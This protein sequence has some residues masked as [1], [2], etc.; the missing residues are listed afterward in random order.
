MK[1][2]QTYLIESSMFASLGKGT[3]SDE[4]VGEGL[5]KEIEHNSYWSLLEVVRNAELLI[6][7]GTRS[8]TY[9]CS[10]QFHIF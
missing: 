2:Y 9:E 8:L 1:I 7:M 6:A 5:F 3:R 10:S 4:G